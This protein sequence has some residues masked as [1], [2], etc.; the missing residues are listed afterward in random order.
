YLKYKRVDSINLFQGDIELYSNVDR[1]RRED[2]LPINVMD[3][4]K[5]VPEAIGIPT[6]ADLRL[7]KNKTVRYKISSNTI[8]QQLKPKIKDAIDAWSTTGLRFEEIGTSV[9]DYIFFEASNDYRFNSSPVGRVGMGKQYIRLQPTVITGI[10]IH[11]IGHSLGLWHEH[12]RPDRDR[13]IK[14]HEDNITPGYKS[15]FEVVKDPFSFHGTSYDYG[16]IMHYG[17]SA[18]GK[19]GPDGKKLTT[20]QPLRNATIGQRSRPS[21]DDIKAIKKMYQL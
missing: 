11:E 8:T 19:T 6:N 10:I 17:T 18:F 2:T 12:T 15:E 13:F 9:G 20:I 14:V 3:S 21:A 4:V 16:S 1:V 5:M 7:W